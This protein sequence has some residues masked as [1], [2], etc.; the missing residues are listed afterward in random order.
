[1]QHLFRTNAGVLFGNDVG[2]GWDEVFYRV[3]RHSSQLRSI[4]IFFYRRLLVSIWE[5]EQFSCCDDAL[6]YDYLELR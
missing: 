4:L 3:L 1:M 6:S 2:V 5:E